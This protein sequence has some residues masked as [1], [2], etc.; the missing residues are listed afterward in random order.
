MYYKGG[1][2]SNTDVINSY[3]HWEAT[4]KNV[5]KVHTLCKLWGVNKFRCVNLKKVIIFSHLELKMDVFWSV[6]GFR[7]M[8]LISLR[9]N[10]T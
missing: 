4:K 6:L 1:L 5:K 3:I 9:R 10:R 7:S 8:V 2:V